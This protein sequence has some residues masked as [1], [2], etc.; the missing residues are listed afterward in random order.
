M[1]MMMRLSEI[2]MLES[3]MTSKEKSDKFVRVVPDDVYKQLE[4]QAQ[5]VLRMM[6]E[7]RKP[8]DEEVLE[9][10][11]RYMR[12]SEDINPIMSVDTYGVSL[13]LTHLIG[14]K[15]KS[16]RA[17]RYYRSLLDAW[18]R[19]KINRQEIYE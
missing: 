5:F 11:G 7:K 6:G 1:V 17:K 12:K 4:I 3:G 18:L 15:K 2:L 16:L 8:S 14:D 9:Y 10:M 13:V 19:S